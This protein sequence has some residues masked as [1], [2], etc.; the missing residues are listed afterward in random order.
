MILDR[1]VDFAL[2]R[3]KI[4]SKYAKDVLNYVEKRTSMQ[5]ELAKNLTKLV[6]SSRPQLQEEIFLPFQSIYCLALDQDLE[7]CALT[8]ASCGLLQGC[9]V[10]NITFL[11]FI[12]CEIFNYLPFYLAK[13]R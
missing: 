3:A 8:Q 13:L 5:M 11:L 10:E 1:G 9:K 7:M 12:Y 2:E 4:W 6:Q